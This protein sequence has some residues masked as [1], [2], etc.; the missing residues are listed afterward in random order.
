MTP[1]RIRR[2][3]PPSSDFFG[4]SFEKNFNLAKKMTKKIFFLKSFP[5]LYCDSLGPTLAFPA[6]VFARYHFFEPWC[7]PQNDPFLTKK[8]EKVFFGPKGDIFVSKEWYGWSRILYP[9]RSV[10]FHS[11]LRV[12]S[13]AQ[14]S[15]LVL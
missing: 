12:I 14:M 15:D 3:G 11:C 10:G 5:L 1:P 6:V 13:H 4:K 8:G 7:A 2:T 9:I